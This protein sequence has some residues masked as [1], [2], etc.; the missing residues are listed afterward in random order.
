MARNFSQRSLAMDLLR[1][2]GKGVLITAFIAIPNLGIALRPLLRHRRQRPR[3]SRI[4]QTLQ[5][6]HHR[7]YIHV[8]HRKGKVAYAIT[9]EGKRFIAGASLAVKIPKQV[10]WDGKWR[11]L[12]FDIPETKGWQR[13]IFQSALRRA[14]FF[15]LQRSVFVTPFPCQKEIREVMQTLNFS[16]EEVMILET[17]SLETSE[18]QL[19]AFFYY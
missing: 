15:P 6:L 14:R 13:R 17:S 10:P 4:R 18:R 19:R 1:V 2:I 16:S 8:F 5:A 12:L 3:P 7:G 9:N 11:I